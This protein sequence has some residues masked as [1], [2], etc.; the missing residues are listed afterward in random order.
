MHG[1]QYCAAMTIDSLTLD[2][3]K[4]IGNNA[5]CDNYILGGIEPINWAYITRSGVSQAPANP[6]FTGTFDDPNFAAVNPDYAKEPMMNP[7]DKV[8][9]HMHDTADGLR[10]DLTDTTTRQTGSMTASIANG[11]GHILYKPGAQKCRWI[12]MRSIPS[13]APRTRAGT[14]GRRTPTTW[15]SQTR[16]GT[17]RTA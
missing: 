9:I 12:P 13:T 4:N 16:S 8:I 1:T 14:L 10:I 17:S 7:G 15:R 11:F 6:L 2:Q 3:N 5:D